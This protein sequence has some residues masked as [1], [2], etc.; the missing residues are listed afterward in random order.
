M[1][2]CERS[3]VDSSVL[4]AATGADIT[5]ETAADAHHEDTDADK[6]Y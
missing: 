5:T 4:H 1:Q 6:E 2:T 3:I